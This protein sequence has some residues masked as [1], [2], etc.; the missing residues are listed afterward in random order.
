MAWPRRS[1]SSWVNDSGLARCDP[2]LLADQV[3]ARDQLGH[4]VLDLQAGVHLQE[5]ELAVLIEEL[6]RAG[7]DVAARPRHLHSRFAHGLAQLGWEVRCR[8]LLDELLVTALGGAVALAHPDTAAV[9]VGDDLHLDVARPGE[10]AL[11]VA[12]G[13]SE[14]LQGLGLGRLQRARRILR[15]LHDPH[16]TAATAVGGLDRDRPAVLLAEGDHLVGRRQELGRARH[17]SD[18]GL[19]R[20]DAARH[21]VAHH[22]DGLGRRADEGDATL[23]DGALRSRCSRRRSR[24]R[25]AHRQ[26]RTAR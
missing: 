13:A 12:L 3:D 25:G 17:A 21:L 8:A 24:S 7:V 10:V 4:R 16:A 11:D 19:L 18:A 20:G 15:R 23:G 26:R 14:A 5:P 6:D 9:R 22:L 2:D 1:T